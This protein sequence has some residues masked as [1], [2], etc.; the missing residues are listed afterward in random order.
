MQT[1][2]RTACCSACAKIV[3]EIPRAISQPEKE[4]LDQAHTDEQGG[5][6]GRI[7]E[8]LNSPRRGSYFLLHGRG[9][10]RHRIPPDVRLVWVPGFLERDVCT[11]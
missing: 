2:T 11:R 6:I 9:I 3:D 7:P 5:S 10:G 8:C 4:I 1:L